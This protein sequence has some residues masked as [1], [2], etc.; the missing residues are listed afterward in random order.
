MALRQVAT[1][2]LASLEQFQSELIEAGF[3]PV[4]GSLREWIGPIAEALKQ[5][6]TASTMRIVFRDGWPFQY[7]Q[8]FVDGIDGLHMN[9][10]GE[11]CLWHS[12]AAF[13]HWLAFSGYVLRIEEWARRAK[14]GGFRPED[15]ALDA[16]LAFGEIRPGAMATIELDSLRLNASAGGIA[17][18]S[19]R[20]KKAEY[21]L[22]VCAGNEG[23]IDGRAYWLTDVRTA[24]RDLNAVRS[25]LSLS[26][27][28]NFDRRYRGVSGRGKPHLFLAAWRRELGNE[29]LVILAEKRDGQVAAEA[30][31]VAPTDMEY[32]KLRTGPDA[33]LLFEKRVVIFGAGA[34]GSN[35]AFR[36]AEAGLGKLT[37]VDRD[38]LRPGDIV[39]HASH[40]WA[41]GRE[42]VNAIYADLK[43]RTPW[44]QVE[45]IVECPWNHLRVGEIAEDADCVVDATG[46]TGFTTM[47]S[48]LFVRTP[49]PLICT[50]LFRAGSVARVRRQARPSDTHI[51][52]RAGHRSYPEIPCGR[53]PF[54]Y[55]PGCSAP[56]NNASPVVVAATSALTAAMVIDF[57]TGRAAYGDEVIEVFRALDKSPFDRV[58]TVIS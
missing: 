15:F 30:F 57:L 53:E 43:V 56:V 48:M 35:V 28:H 38:R 6:T 12:G 50:A 31:E 13:D 54:S 49:T 25:L 10:A 11:L 46:L 34:I 27:Q 3:E 7:P 32:L 1:L 29:A 20:W 26:Q 9:A 2:D 37:V 33:D 19:G 39:R 16:H 45:P 8:L 44:T 18:I 14:K 40:R 55:E 52:D 51:T 58:G 47:L 42:K 41:I 22:E 5:F 21:V 36:L 23:P 17:A 4:P 24:P